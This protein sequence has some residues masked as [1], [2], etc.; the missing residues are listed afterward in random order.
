MCWTYFNKYIINIISRNYY[1]C[2]EK[3]ILSIIRLTQVYIYYID[4]IIILH[5]VCSVFY[6]FK[7]LNYLNNAP[8]PVS[9]SNSLKC[10]TTLAH[11]FTS[12]KYDLMRKKIHCTTKLFTHSEF[13][14][15]NSSRVLILFNLL[16]IIFLLLNHI[17]FLF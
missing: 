12:L 3:F 5:N 14:N 2:E 8:R 9:I 16:N 15:N 6:F 13:E 11:I 7:L 17:L 1:I 4:I 10:F